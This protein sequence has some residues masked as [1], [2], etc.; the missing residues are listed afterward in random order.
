MKKLILSTILFLGLT[1]TGFSQETT[2]RVQKSP[3]ERAQRMTDMLDK[4]LSLS[5]NQ[6]TQIYQV[7]LERAQAISNFQ[8]DRKT[9]DKAQMKAK[10]EASENK[11]VSILN[12]S[13]RVTYAQLKAERE[14]RMKNHKR[15]HKKGP[16]SNKA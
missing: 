7:S 3:E 13:Q 4:K 6:K 14:E 10:F 11:I 2:Q 9:V 8:G 1:A 16:K 5:E 15:G 12:D